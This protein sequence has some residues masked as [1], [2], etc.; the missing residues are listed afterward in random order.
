MAQIIITLNEELDKEVAIYK[1][2]H[3]FKT[4]ANVVEH[5]VEKVLMNDKEGVFSRVFGVD[6]HEKENS[7]KSRKYFICNR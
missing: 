7:W 3:N 6:K 4:K 1:I 5:L 2:K